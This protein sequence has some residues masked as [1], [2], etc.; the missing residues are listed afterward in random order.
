MAREENID[1]LIIG[2]GASGGVA[3]RHLAEKGF[4]VVCLEQGEWPDRNNFRGAEDDWEIAIRK[5]WAL[6]PN[7]R[8]LDSDY[9]VNA[10]KSDIEILA[11]G[12]GH[13]VSRYY[14]KAIKITD[15][16]ELGDVM[17]SQLSSMFDKKKNLH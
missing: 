14:N 1:V 9:P 16:N 13:D 3:A 4:S 15:V 12:I 17:I 11:I 5:D 7:I 10:E 8:K 2:A 6:S